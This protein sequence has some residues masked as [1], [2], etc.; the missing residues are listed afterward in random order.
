[1]KIKRIL[2]LIVIISAGMFPVL[3]QMMLQPVAAV[4]LIR[5]EM[6][7]RDALDE[8]VAELQAAN[9][10]QA[11]DEAEALDIMIN[12][13]LVLQ[14]AE[15]VGIVLLDKDLDTLVAKQRISVESQVGRVLTDAEFASVILQA[16]NM[17]LEDFRMTN[18]QNYIVNTYIRQEKSEIVTNIPAPTED[19]IKAFHKKSA[20][21][22]I[23]PEYIHLSHIFISKNDP[24]TDNAKEKAD[25]VYRQYEY[26]TKNY[27]ALVLEF[28][29][30]ESS[31]F[32][33][34]D[35]GWLAIDDTI[36][37]QVFGDN[38]IDS[39]FSLDAGN[40]S[41]VLESKTGYHI[42][43]ILDHLPA[44]LL[45]LDDPLSPE[46]AMTVRQYISQTLYVENQQA[47]FSA[48]VL[49]LVKELREEAEITILL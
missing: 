18:K 10:G 29:Q 30:D 21:S 43:S 26:G 14:G 41:K 17:T 27:D 11:V 33:G 38:L 24:A 37:R 40:I 7:S 36:N 22:F 8:F 34:G 28:S 46:N 35:I 25:A 15:K 16:Y 1:M 20:V 31:K 23:N 5:S 9:G 19:E 47:A 45:S 32:L 48:A 44:R 2:L 3:S 39:V 4:N 42:V 13:I 12:D 6:I 49:E